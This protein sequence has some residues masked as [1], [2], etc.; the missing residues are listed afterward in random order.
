MTLGLTVQRKQ[1]SAE[2]EYAQK[3]KLLYHMCLAFIL[4][5]YNVVFFHVIWFTKKLDY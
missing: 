1:K 2:V 3:L 5:M 4:Q